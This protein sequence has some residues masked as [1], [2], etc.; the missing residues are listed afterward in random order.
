MGAGRRGASRRDAVS[1]AAVHAVATPQQRAHARQRLAAD[2]E[3]SA[4]VSANAGSGKTTV[5][6]GRVLRL[7]LDGVP[8]GKILCLTYTKAAAA[9]MANRVFAEL[10]RW[11]AMDEAALASA[12]LTIEGR[13]PDAGRRLRAR[14]LFAQA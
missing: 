8:P 14:R 13:R 7:L 1:E 2:P 3:L 11:T 12:I 5:L 4:F 6:V 10:A 9:N